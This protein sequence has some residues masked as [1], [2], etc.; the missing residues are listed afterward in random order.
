MIPR[1]KRKFAVAILASLSISG[2]LPAVRFRPCPPTSTAHCESPAVCTAADSQPFVSTINPV[3]PF[4]RIVGESAP[5]TSFAELEL[6]AAELHSEL[7]FRG[8]IKLEDSALVAQRQIDSCDSPASCGPRS[9]PTDMPGQGMPGQGMA[10]D[11]VQPG[12]SI[13]TMS[14]H[15]SQPLLLNNNGGPTEYL[16]ASFVGGAMPMTSA[17]GSNFEVAVIVNDF[18]PYR[19]MQLA[20]TFIVRDLATGQEVQRIQKVWRGV[21]HKP[22][23]ED[24]RKKRNIDLKHPATRQ[25]LEY[26]ALPD[27]SPRHLIKR[28]ATDVANSLCES[29]LGPQP[30]PSEQYSSAPQGF[31]LPQ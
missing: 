30:S 1:Q 19:P 26:N 21:V 7:A 4:I 10:D 15:T 13:Q 6:L 9:W 24:D 16:D 12:G 25:R 17:A 20:A 11:D 14:A 5:P 2:C 31:H 23:F 28:A 3:T 22:E 27:I 29:L 8:G 18:T